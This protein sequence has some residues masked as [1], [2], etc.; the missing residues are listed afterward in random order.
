MRLA[1]CLTLTALPVMAEEV[2]VPSGQPVT[3]L[4]AILNEAGPDG[5]TARFRFVAPGIAE[6]GGVAFETAASDMAYLCE[7]YALPRIAVTG[8]M[9]AQVVISLS[10]R[11]VPFG[12]AAPEVTQ[13]FEAY[14]ID[15]ATCIWEAF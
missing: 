8:P 5:M 13:F 10:D 11:P 15:G 9:P 4:E 2:P 12:Q 6:G 1:V 14:S 3:F 7:T